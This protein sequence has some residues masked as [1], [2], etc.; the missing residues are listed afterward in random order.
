MTPRDPERTRR[1]LLDA[2]A[3]V[4][5]EHYTIA[6]RETVVLPIT[7]TSILE[8]T[9]GDP[10][11]P[12][13]G[14]AISSAFGSKSA[15]LQEVAI[16]YLAPAGLAGAVTAA[17]GG[18]LLEAAEADLA[19]TVAEVGKAR[20][21]WQLHAHAAQ[22]VIREQLVNIYRHFDGALA[23]AYEQWSSQ[24]PGG[25]VVDPRILA[26]AVT[27]LTE[28]LALRLLADDDFDL[29]DA[30]AVQELLLGALSPTE[31]L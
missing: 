15:F 30:K 24:A 12:I 27:A 2:A 20:H 5:D 29:A 16:D 6:T 11:G 28:G 26:A 21:Y 25:R 7:M 31:E 10:E 22:P 14:G 1:R 18:S 4:L 23:S 8:A 17:T 9:G 19:G 13:T 3:R